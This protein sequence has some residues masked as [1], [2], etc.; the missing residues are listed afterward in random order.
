MAHDS[1]VPHIG[2]LVTPELLTALDRVFPLLPPDLD[3]SERKIFAAA[4]SRRVIDFMRRQF[5]ERVA[6]AL[7]G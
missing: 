3:D 4:G 2:H 1:D 7:S 6:N 5:D